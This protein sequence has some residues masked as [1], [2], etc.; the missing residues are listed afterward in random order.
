MKKVRGSRASV[1]VGYMRLTDAAPFV[2]AQ[3]LDYF[4]QA[5]INVSLSREVSWASVRDK[6]VA[7][8]LDAAQLLA[9]LLAMTTLGASGI[10]APLLTGLVLSRN[11]N[12]ITLSS[13]LA[14]RLFE[15]A[16]ASG[17]RP[18]ARLLQARKRPL[19]VASVHAFSSHTLL[20]R[21]WLRHEG[22]D[23]DVD[24]R[25]I[26]VPPTQMGDSLSSGLIDG[27]CAGEP[28]NTAAVFAGTGKIVSGGSTL[29]PNAPEKVLA[30]TQAWHDEHFEVHAALRLALLRAC[31]EINSGRLHS[32]LVPMLSSPDYL[33]LPDE[34]VSPALSGTLPGHSMFNDML[35]ERD[36]LLFAGGSV[37]CPDPV[38][39]LR[40]ITECAQILGRDISPNVAQVVARQTCR[41]DL[42]R[43]TAALLDR[44]EHALF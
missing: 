22:V 4:A 37:N 16:S 44:E 1:K 23:P 10:K 27:F 38:E 42:Y 28:W 19:T 12:A 18:L 17:Q 15:N 3:E 36:F 32:D 31:L 11:G 25:F 14:D 9:P 7:G 8:A 39:T 6:L 5:G 30:V 34:I 33:D 43:T 29:Q 26:V 20:L 35:G 24:A 21:R 2:V 40:G 41:S 13:E